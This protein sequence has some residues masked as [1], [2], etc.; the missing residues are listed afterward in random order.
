MFSRKELDTKH[1][2]DTL[3]TEMS[4][5]DPDLY[6]S[7]IHAIIAEIRQKYNGPELKELLLNI[8]RLEEYNMIKLARCNKQLEKQLISLQNILSDSLEKIP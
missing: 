7:T 1:S 8:Q 6:R 3:E 2:I 5:L 4:I